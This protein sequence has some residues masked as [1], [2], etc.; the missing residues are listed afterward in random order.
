MGQPHGFVKALK[1][2][3]NDQTKLDISYDSFW[4]SNAF[5]IPAF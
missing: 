2:P 5:E 4:L 1:K 3:S